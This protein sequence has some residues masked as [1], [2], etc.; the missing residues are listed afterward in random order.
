MVINGNLSENRNI[1]RSS[2]SKVKNNKNSA[3]EESSKEWCQQGNSSDD[4]KWIVA[5]AE[6][7]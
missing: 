3:K 5:R 7:K 4:V 1:K 6:I 2:I